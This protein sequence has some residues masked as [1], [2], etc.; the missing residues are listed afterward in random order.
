MFN[1][2]KRNIKW[3]ENKLSQ[4]LLT[5][6][7]QQWHIKNP[8]ILYYQH[9]DYYMYEN[10]IEHPQRTQLVNYKASYPTWRVPGVY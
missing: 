5:T 6:K 1:L 4:N 7:Y 10:T 3:R 2:V 9:F 8:S